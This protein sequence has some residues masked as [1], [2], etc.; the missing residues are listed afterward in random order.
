VYSRDTGRGNSRE[1]GG[2]HLVR[3]R[4][5][6]RRPRSDRV[7]RHADPRVRVVAPVRSVRGEGRDVSD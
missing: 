3:P 1:G 7:L 4:A 5:A 2:A 6:R